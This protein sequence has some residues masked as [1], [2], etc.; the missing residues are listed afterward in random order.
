ML[1]MLD[2]AAE[3]DEFVDRLPRF[4]VF[5]AMLQMIDCILPD[6]LGGTR[7][8]QRYNTARLCR[9]RWPSHRADT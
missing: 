1:G 4:P 9:Y 6:L 5:S 2:V 7:R 8:R 3:A